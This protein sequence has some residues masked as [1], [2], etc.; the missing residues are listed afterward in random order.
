MK[1]FQNIESEAALQ[2]PLTIA[3]F[4]IYDLRKLENFGKRVWDTQTAA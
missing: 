4:K 1:F 2:I 3:N